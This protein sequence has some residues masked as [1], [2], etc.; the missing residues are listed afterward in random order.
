MASYNGYNGLPVYYEY[1]NLYNGMIDPST[2]H[3]DSTLKGYFM[4]YLLERVFSV[5]EFEGLD[6]N[7]NKSYFLYTLFCLGFVCFFKTDKYGVIPQHCTL[8]GRGL[9]Y[10]PTTCIISNPLLDKAYQ[11]RIGRECE[12]VKLQP[13]YSG[14]MDIISYYSDM[15][16]LS[17]EAITSNLVNS[18][19]AYVF[20]VNNKQE[21]ESFKKLFD[22]LNANNPS[23][24]ADKKLFNEDGTPNWLM[25][26]QN[27]KQ[28]Y[29]TDDLLVDMNKWL[30]MFNTEIGIPNANTEKKERLLTD[31]VNANNVDT[32]S[33]ASVWLESIQEGLD[34]V[35]AMFNTNISV[36]FRF[37]LKDTAENEKEVVYG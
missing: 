20:M 4:K 8:S 36:R 23:V 24:Y 31:E 27:L 19:M 34:K 25:F 18:K 2:V 16:A 11:L 15:L 30:D 9:Y 5:Y 35:N 17:S 37:D 32:I 29:I 33:K 12:L 28:T 10:Q 21:A 7:W 14:V 6:E 1:N 22:E 3:T 26:N 13:N